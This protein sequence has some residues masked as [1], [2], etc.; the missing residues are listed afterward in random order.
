MRKEQ[1]APGTGI[2]LIVGD[3]GEVRATLEGALRADGFRVI[4]AGDGEAGLEYL[5]FGL[6]PC[7]VL[8]DLPGPRMTS[9]EFIAAA[10]RLPT[11]NGVPLIVLGSLLRQVLGAQRAPLRLD[12]LLAA[13]EERAGLTPAG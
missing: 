8:V 10:R 11:A 4:C 9:E 1:S 3:T 2:V 6:Q 12:E 5:R 7:L 13:L